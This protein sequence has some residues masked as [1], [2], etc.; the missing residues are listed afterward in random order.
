ML[1]EPEKRQKY[2]MYGEDGLKPDGG[3]GGGGGF[4]DFFGG[5][6]GGRRQGADSDKRKPDIPM[7]IEVTLQELYLGSARTVSSS[8]AATDASRAY[9]SNVAHAPN[10]V[11]LRQQILCTACRGTGSKG[12]E[13]DKCKVCKGQGFT[14]ERRQVGPGKNTSTSSFV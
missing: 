2:D 10:Q 9:V 3:G 5:F 14:L 12:G 8:P 11:K 6:G 7:D 4:G 13:V 1:S